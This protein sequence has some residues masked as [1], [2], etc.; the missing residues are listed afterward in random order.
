CS[1]N[2]SVPERKRKTADDRHADCSEK[3]RARVGRE[4]RSDRAPLPAV[5]DRTTPPFAPYRRLRRPVH[6]ARSQNARPKD[7]QLDNQTRAS[8]HAKARCGNG[9]R[10]NRSLL[11]LYFIAFDF[12]GKIDPPSRSYVGQASC[13]TK[14]LLYRASCWF[15]TE[16]FSVFLYS[17]WS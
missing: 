6:F 1:Q 4:D 14:T 17:G 10:K 16:S 12:V 8:H 13:K 15:A 9:Q 11:C 7:R 2:C 5:L 3:R